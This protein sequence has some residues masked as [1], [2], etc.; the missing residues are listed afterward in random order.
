LASLAISYPSQPEALA[1]LFWSGKGLL[2]PED[3]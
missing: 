3:T 1:A 2:Q